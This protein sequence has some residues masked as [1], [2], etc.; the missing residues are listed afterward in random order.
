MDKVLTGIVVDLLKI[1]RSS[2]EG[3]LCKNA[4]FEGKMEVKFFLPVLE[5]R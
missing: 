1:V 5:I 4:E 2:F 3:L